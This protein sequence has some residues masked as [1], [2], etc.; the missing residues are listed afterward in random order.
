MAETIYHPQKDTRANAL[1]RNLPTSD[2]ASI[3]K[4]IDQ[5]SSMA[6]N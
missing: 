5:N 3:D 2:A 1:V 4:R 6:V